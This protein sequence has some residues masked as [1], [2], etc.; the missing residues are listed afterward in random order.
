MQSKTKQ[1]ARAPR[2]PPRAQLRVKAQLQAHANHIERFF[3]LA[4][5]QGL[6]QAIRQVGI[7]SAAE[8]RQFR[9]LYDEAPETGKTVKE[10]TT[11]R[12]E[13]TKAALAREAAEREEKLREEEAAREKAAV[14]QARAEEIEWINQEAKESIFILAGM[15]QRPA[16]RATIGCAQV[17][18]DDYVR[19]LVE[20]TDDL[21]DYLWD[22]VHSGTW[23]CPEVK[24]ALDLDQLVGAVLHLEAAHSHFPPSTQQL[25][26]SLRRKWQD[27]ACDETDGDPRA[28]TTQ[29]A[30]RHPCSA[31]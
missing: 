6:R 9:A 26:A 23:V 2:F 27:E 16:T 22:K 29:E 17:L 3:Q 10:D 24:E 19:R 4:Q 25:A 20:K 8:I 30:D 31:S 1:R 18:Q 13:E 5:V 21:L 28:S 11:Q 14:E 12:A 15:G 7:G